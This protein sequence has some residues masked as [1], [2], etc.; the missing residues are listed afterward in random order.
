MKTT[1]PG[2]APGGD[3]AGAQ[4]RCFTCTRADSLRT[5]METLSL[6]GVSRLICVEAASQRIEGIVTLSDVANF[7]FC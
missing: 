2:G 1:A 7:L 5:V 3:A 4:R 6:P